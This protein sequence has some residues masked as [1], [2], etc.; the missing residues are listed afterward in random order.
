[1]SYED[2]PHQGRRDGSVV[3]CS[4]DSTINASLQ[5]GPSLIP[6]VV[7]ICGLSLLLILVHGPRVLSRYSSFP[8][9]TKTNISILPFDLE[10]M[11]MHL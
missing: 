1:M 5:C 6:G 11:V 9:S 10:H 8:P 7:A 4:G 2:T 3:N